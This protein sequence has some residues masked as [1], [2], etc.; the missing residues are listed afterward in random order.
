MWFDNIVIGFGLYGMLVGGIFALQRRLMY[1]PAIMISSPQA[2]GLSDIQEV[3]LTAKDGIKL[4]I[5]AYAARENYPTIVYFHGNAGNLADRAAKFSAFIDQGF[6]LVALSYR[7]FG[8]SQGTP[9]EQGLY[10]DARAAIHYATQTLN[11]K[12]HQLIYFGESLGSGIAVQMATEITPGLVI[13]EAAYTSVETRSAELFPYVLA[14]RYLV[15]DKYD[16]LSKISDVHTPLLML[17]GEKD[18]TI[19]LTHGKT[20][21]AA[22]NEPKDLIIYPHVYHTDYSI[23]EILKPV[24][25]AAE[26]YGLILRN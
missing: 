2:H 13:L 5:W 21:F 26:K 4:Q 15:L 19:P 12:P 1:F 11:V 16:S 3:F 25:K 23:E 9:S 17:H 8:K 18:A 22:A 10:A 7:G 20:L 14:A 24:V 6:G